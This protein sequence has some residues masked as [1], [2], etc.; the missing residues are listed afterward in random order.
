MGP[1]SSLLLP[2]PPIPLAL[3]GGASAWPWPGSSFSRPEA[4]AGGGHGEESPERLPSPAGLPRAKMQQQPPDQT[5][6]PLW[7][8]TAQ[9]RIISQESGRR[10]PGWPQGWSRKARGQLQPGRAAHIKTSRALSAPASR[11]LALL[12]QTLQT[13]S[14]QAWE[15]GGARV[16]LGKQAG[17]K[18]C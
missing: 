4:W 18:R 14:G 15:E 3:Q 10:E 11:P 2:P 17:C 5:A 8:S 7:L 6:L 12:G 9:G 16:F 13:R 1:V